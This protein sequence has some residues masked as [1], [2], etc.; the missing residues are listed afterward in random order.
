MSKYFIYY[1]IALLKKGLTEKRFGCKLFFK[2]RTNQKNY[3]LY[4]DVHN[5]YQINHFN[6]YVG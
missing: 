3:N 5:T 6:S 4:Q 1:F 2:N